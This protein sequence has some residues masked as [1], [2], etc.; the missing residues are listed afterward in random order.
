MKNRSSRFL[1][2]L[3]ILVLIVLGFDAY[4]QVMPPAHAA[5]QFANIVCDNFSAVSSATSVQVIT[6]GG[7]NQFIYICSVGFGSIA[8]STFSIVEGTGST[9]ATNIKAMSGGTTAAAGVGL[10]A[11][12]TFTEGSG[13]GAILKTAVAGDNVC[14]IAAG[15]G[16]LAGAV[17][18]TSG[19]Y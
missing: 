14:I 16:P 1:A 11:N 9:C 7:T 19:P 13:T 6:A 12:G 10:A 15:T 8:G 2:A 4:Q 17:A 3:A 5:S 18:W